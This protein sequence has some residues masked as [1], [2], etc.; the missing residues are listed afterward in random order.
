MD[1]LKADKLRELFTLRQQFNNRNGYGL[2]QQSNE[3]RS[4]HYHEQDQR[5]KK[6]KQIEQ[7][8]KEINKHT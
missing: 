3:S 7:D 4:M 1:Q 5:L 6:I 8:L 2:I